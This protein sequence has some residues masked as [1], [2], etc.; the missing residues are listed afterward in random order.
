M[1]PS[2]SDSANTHA[3]SSSDSS[4]QLTHLSPSRGFSGHLQSDRGQ[5]TLQNLRQMLDPSTSASFKRSQE[6]YYIPERRLVL[7]CRLQNLP[8]EVIVQISKRLDTVSAICLASTNHIF[9][10]IVPTAAPYELRRCHRW[11]LT[12]RSETD[13]PSLTALPCAFCKARLPVEEF[14]EDS[15]R[16]VRSSDLHTRPWCIDPEIVDLDPVARYCGSH[17]PLAAWVYH[18]STR[19]PVYWER[20][21]KLR[22]MHCGEAVNADDD[23]NDDQETGCSRC[24]C[25]ICPRV[26]HY[27]YIRHGPPKRSRFVPDPKLDTISAEF[28]ER[29]RRYEYSVT[30][31]GSKSFIPFFSRVRFESTHC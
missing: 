29:T 31:W 20:M 3:T 28:S 26:L 27:A 6:Q 7:Y 21:R 30:E 11:L 19:H 1:E 10:N 16:R 17:F 9:R 24:S 22:C 13:K 8:T 23:N 14:T 4:S 18:E 15:S 25:P 12:C 2:T 5:L